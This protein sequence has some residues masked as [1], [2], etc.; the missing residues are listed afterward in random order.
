MSKSK[1]LCFAASSGGHYEQILMLK[2]LMDKYKSFL[3][4][5]KTAYKTELNGE[6]MYYLY[7]I[8]RKEW[9]FP[10]EMIRNSFR[11]HK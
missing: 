11:S 4:T 6:K 3:I 5:E 9:K 1:K 8:N 7:Q 10:F 2:P